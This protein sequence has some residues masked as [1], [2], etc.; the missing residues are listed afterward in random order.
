MLR[1][2][3]TCVGINTRFPTWWTFVEPTNCTSRLQLG[4]PGRSLPM[5][6]TSTYH[7]VEE[8]RN[9]IGSEWDP[10]AANTSGTQDKPHVGVSR[11]LMKEKE[12]K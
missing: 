10:K 12:K 4:Y 2:L 3:S 11:C 6:V 5:R 9:I 8:H 7:A 1:A